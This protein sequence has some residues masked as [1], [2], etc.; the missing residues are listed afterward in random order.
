MAQTPDICFRSFRLDTANE[1]LWRG[2]HKVTLRPKTFAV[3]RYLVEHPGRLITKD[4]LLDAVWPDTSVSDVVPIVCVREI[5]QALGDHPET[6][7]FI[8]TVP[9]RGYRFIAP[10]TSAPPVSSSKFKVQSSKSNGEA[11]DW[12]LETSSSFLQASSLKPQASGLIGREAEL[13]KLH[14]LL[15]I[16]MGGERQFVFVSGEAG[17]GKTALVEAFLK[18]LEARD[19]R[20]APSPQ[21][22]S[23][24]SL[25]SSP[26]L[27]YVQCIEQRGVGE[28]YLPLLDVTNRMCR[29][30]GGERVIEIFRQYAPTW[31]MQFPALLSAADFDD[32]QKR[33]LGAT[34]ERMLREMAEATEVLTAIRPVVLVLEDLH[35]CDSATLDFLAFLARRRGPA[36]LL[37]IGTYRPADVAN[38]G[39]PFGPLKQDLSVHRYCTEIALPLLT[40][41]DVALYLEAQ[42]TIECRQG[43]AL[44]TLAHQLHQ[45]T[46]G[47]PLFLVNVVDY[48]VTHSARE[49]GVGTLA[50]LEQLQQVVPESLQQMVEKQIERLSLEDQE[51]LEVASVVGVDF[52]AAA[53]AAALESDVVVVEGRC[54]ELARREQLLCERGVEEWPDATVATRYGFIHSLYQQVLY[55]RVTGAHRARLHVRIGSRIEEGYGARARE[56]AGVLAMHFMNGRDYRR[57][58]LYSQYA[59]ENAVWRCALQEAN[60]HFAKGVELLH[61]WPDTP[62]RTQQELLFHLIV[63]G[64]LMASKGEAS[65]EVEQ[66]YEQIVKLHRRLGET[67]T[68]FLV[69]LGLWMVRLVRGELA[70]AQE[71]A[72][73]IMVRAEREGEPIM[74]LQAHLMV[75][76][77][78]FY[79]GEFS[80]SHL[81]FTQVATLYETQEHPQYLL[82]PKMLGLSLDS[83]AVWMLGCP[84]AA[85]KQSQDAVAWA[86]ELSHPYNGVAA[87]AVAAWLN[88]SRWEGAN[89]EQQSDELLRVAHTHG[90]IQYVSLGTFL[91]GY[92]KFAQGQSEDGIGLMFHGLDAMR[93][94]KFGVGMSAWLGFLALALGDNDRV[95]EALTMLAQ[96]EAVMESSGERFFAAELWRIKGEILLTKEV[97]SQRA[98]VKSQ[99]SKIEEEDAEL[100]VDFSSSQ[101][102]S[103]KPQAVEEGLR[104]VEGY[105]LKAIA[106]A[107]QQQAKSLEL[108]VVMSLVRLRQQQARG[109]R[110]RNA[111]CGVRSA[112][113]EVGTA[114]TEAHTMLSEVSGWF[115][116]GVTTVDLQAA[117]QLL[118]EVQTSLS[119]RDDR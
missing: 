81:H 67:E 60:A 4:E 29:A 99:K 50:P 2:T 32:L 110:E 68:P 52:S 9:R 43:I 33:T 69:L 62:E 11:R 1:R 103:L 85:A 63:I 30:S 88:V 21:V 116:E 24:K 12:R 47:N 104:T 8:E 82:D 3:L 117:R 105:F 72:A 61:H 113:I 35:W 98:K 26:W 34:Q 75:G 20:L 57:A 106:I 40:E 19:L 119:H 78:A 25:A 74:Q 93:A 114:L 90:F 6:P 71:I 89:A 18:R 94:A 107:R 31:L 66:V 17:I 10:L 112:E 23:L 53:L 76:I 5:R 14:T 15:D 48:L 95:E 65:L 13:A 39:H 91:R 102:S 100:R 97:K 84:E 37:L 58:V 27:A 86:H 80:L 108:R 16:A 49:N 115:A 7:R 36:R 101:A 77:C 22:S 79:R 55:R 70:A 41:S 51:M 83:L 38:T 64:P 87:L 109:Q 56:N 92:A 111:E 96:A 54:R 46:E 28:A 73:Q 45:R 118:A 44:P 59:A 42:L